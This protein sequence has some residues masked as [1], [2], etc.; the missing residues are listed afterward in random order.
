MIRKIPA[1][2]VLR[3]AVA[4][5][6]VVASGVLSQGTVLADP[7]V[8]TEATVSSVG[9]APNIECKWELP[10]M[11]P[12]DGT[13]NPY[14]DPTLEYGTVASPHLHDDD[15]A[16]TPSPLFPCSL[17][18]TGTPTQADG[19][20]EMIQVRP[21]GDDEPEERRV[22]VWAAVDHP[23]GISNISDVYW[24]VFHPD[25]SFKVQVHGIR[26]PLADCGLLGDTTTV[27]TMLE[28][29]HHTG[30]IGATA[31][32]D[33]NRGLVAKCYEQEKAIYYA[34]FSISKEQPCGE[35]RIEAHAVS[36][37]VEDVLTNYIDVVCFFEGVIDF[38][39][40]DFGTIFPG[41]TDIVSGDLIFDPPA[42]DNPTAMNVGNVGMTLAV[43]FDEMCQVGVPG[44]KCIDQFDVAFGRSAATLEWIDPVLASTTVTF[45]TESG[46]TLPTPRPWLDPPDTVLTDTQ[47][48][49]S[50]QVGKIDFSV[51]PPS[52]LPAGAYAGEVDVMFV[53]VRGVCPTD[54]AIVE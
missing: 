43:H 33:P 22:Q 15:M 4:G 31:I 29:A 39:D 49:C 50:N 18:A 21:N 53:A 23:N 13:P 28:A 6:L 36:M 42:D 47:V 11:I 27:G 25:G 26:I 34:D 19:A 30:Q 17:P 24:K 7:T 51:H 1:I 37:G 5:L 44:P 46:P 45:D 3:F 2:R 10:D 38:N 35:Y 9:V 14:P 52:T 40:V 41:L 54:L 12:L 8:P 48:L 16:D 32:T 20:T